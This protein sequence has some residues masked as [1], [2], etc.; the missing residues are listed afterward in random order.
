M[1]NETELNS[2]FS[3]GLLGNRGFKVEIAGVIGS[4]FGTGVIVAVGLMLNLS[5]LSFE[6]GS[7]GVK[8]TEGAMSLLLFDE[9]FSNEIDGVTD[10]LVDFGLPVAGVRVHDPKMEKNNLEFHNVRGTS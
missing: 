9:I 10:T 7:E 1:L 4:F 3:K 8:V 6:P 5:F 2:A